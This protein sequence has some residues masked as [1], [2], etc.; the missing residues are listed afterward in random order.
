MGIGERRYQILGIGEQE[1]AGRAV[2]GLGGKSKGKKVVVKT[3]Q[4]ASLLPQRAEAEPPFLR[5]ERVAESSVPEPGRMLLRQKT[6]IQEIF[7]HESK[8][9]VH[10]SVTVQMKSRWK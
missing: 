3:D 4:R 9:I 2:I 7:L 10:E 5:R 1:T 6:E 8:E